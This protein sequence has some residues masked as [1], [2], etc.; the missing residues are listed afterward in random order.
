MSDFISD[1]KSFYYIIKKVTMYGF[2]VWAKTWGKIDV[3]LQH[4]TIP[5]GNTVS[6]DNWL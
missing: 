2:L 3:M 5:L 4:E 1:T 6:L